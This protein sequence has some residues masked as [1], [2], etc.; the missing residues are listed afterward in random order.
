[1]NTVLNLINYHQ[2]LAAFWHSLAVTFLSLLSMN[3]SSHDDTSRLLLSF[4]LFK[5]LYRIVYYLIMNLSVV[6]VNKDLLWIIFSLKIYAI[7]FHFKC[8]IEFH[9]Q[10]LS[11]CLNS[12]IVKNTTFLSLLHN[13]ILNIW[14][15]WLRM[16]SRIF[17][18][19]LA[20][21]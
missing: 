21:I 2:M 19:R 17:V 9:S 13:F 12:F 18:F 4:R 3:Y 15:L 20:E 8:G 1:M 16:P 5:N 7:N 10:A 14:A 11:E 6:E